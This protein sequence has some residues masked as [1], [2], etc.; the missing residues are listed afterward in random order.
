MGRNDKFFPDR[1]AVQKFKLSSPPCGDLQDTL[2]R[3]DDS[4][5]VFRFINCERNDESAFAVKLELGHISLGGEMA[6]PCFA[7]FV[8]LN[9]FLFRV[10]VQS[11]ALLLVSNKR[12][13]VPPEIVLA[14]RFRPL[15]YSLAD[16]PLNVSRVNFEN[17]REFVK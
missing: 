10:P 11:L 8:I 1:V 9:A 16:K 13:H 2:F 12:R 5:G 3:C 17:F 7:E 15:K 14:A 6:Q 4:R